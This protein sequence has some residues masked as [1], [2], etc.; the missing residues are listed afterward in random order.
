MFTTTSVCAR[1]YHNSS[2][3]KPCLIFLK[4]F[5]LLKTAHP[6]SATQLVTHNTRPLQGAS[7]QLLQSF[8]SVFILDCWFQ[9]LVN[10]SKIT[11]ASNPT[12]YDNSEEERRKKSRHLKYCSPLKETL[13]TL[14]DDFLIR[15]G[16][17][18][19]IQASHISPPGPQLRLGTSRKER[20]QSCR[21]AG[22]KDGGLTPLLILEPIFTY[23]GSSR[24]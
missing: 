4:S 3:S 9:T 21:L 23:P 22:R 12:G 7:S 15:K 16:R 17:E 2:K 14:W 8:I 20:A 18:Y 24:L 1:T 6:A 19:K 10:Q 13:G 5:P 11:E